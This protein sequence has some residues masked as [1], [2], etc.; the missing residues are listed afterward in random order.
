MEGYAKLANLM[1]LSPELSILR[2]F[3]ALRVQ[4]LLYLQAELTLIEERLHEYAKT[5][6]AAGRIAYALDWKQL[7]KSFTQ[8]PLPRSLGEIDV[9][10]DDQRQWPTMLLMRKKLDEYGA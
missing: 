8:R 7:H 4:N 1:A 9:L 5:D 2:N 3:T 10:P 6:S